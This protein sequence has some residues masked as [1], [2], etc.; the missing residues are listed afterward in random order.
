MPMTS[1]ATSTAAPTTTLQPFLDSGMTRLL[2]GRPVVGRGLGEKVRSRR[3]P[4]ERAIDYRDE[5]GGGER[6][7][8]Q[9]AA[10]GPLRQPRLSPPLS[11][12][13]HHPHSGGG[14]GQRG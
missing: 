13:G 2:W 11:R 5:G 12:R 8:G 10:Q 3:A 6:G 14:H 4:A 1:S 9:S 7:R